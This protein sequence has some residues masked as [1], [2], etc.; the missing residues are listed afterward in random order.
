MHVGTYIGAPPIVY[1]VDGKEYM[2]ILTGGGLSPRLVGPYA[3]KESYIME[4]VPMLLVFS[5]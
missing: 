1:A 5:L 4:S 2:A 3:N